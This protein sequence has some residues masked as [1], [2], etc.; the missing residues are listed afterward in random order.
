M[1]LS[2]LAL[3]VHIEIVFC[4]EIKLYIRTSVPGRSSE[5]EE[6]CAYSSANNSY[7]IT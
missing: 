7:Y 5:K 6:P 1:V 4:A 2:M 3:N